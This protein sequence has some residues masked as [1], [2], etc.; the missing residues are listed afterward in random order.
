MKKTIIM[1]L[2]LAFIGLVIWRVYEKIHRQMPATLSQI[3]TSQGLP[4][5]TASVTRQTI[6]HTINVTGEVR[7][8]QEA[9]LSFKIGGRV[10][11]LR[12]NTGDQVTR[13]ELLA[14]LD[15][16]QMQI[17]RSQALNQ[18]AIAEKNLSQAQLRLENSRREWE[19][20]RRLFQE[21][22]IASAQ[23]ERYELEYKTAVEQEAAS[24]ASLETV[25]EGLKLIEENLQ[26]A[27]LFAPFSGLI[28]ESRT[29]LG[30]VVAPGQTIYTLYNTEKLII[31][32]QVP[33]KDVLQL[34][35]GQKAEFFNP[36]LSEPV[37]RA[38]VTRMAAAPDAKTKLY[39][40]ELTV[41]SRSMIL[42]PGLFVQ[43]TIT[44]GR[45]SGVL[46]VPVQALL[47]A[48]DTY[49][50]YVV[51][52]G[53]AE[54]RNVLVGETSG[55]TVEILSGLSEGDQVITLGKENVSSGT[56]VKVKSREKN[57]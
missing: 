43:G 18:I 19:R 4:V 6:I 46:T 51:R 54:R 8:E 50:V 42:K 32:A 52:E 39:T 17:Q 36:Y 3:Q 38:T 21:G 41:L 44:T 45:K 24:R 14:Q 57:I 12:K 28:G 53:K 1:V 34:K 35:A 55:Q 37:I 23:L 33:E 40:V 7:C 48:G 25:R 20:R 13:G 15:T 5:E 29:E 56:R 9:L 27:C 22:V 26:D 47:Q 11:S 49:S 10:T 16:S 31:R 2:A 30:E